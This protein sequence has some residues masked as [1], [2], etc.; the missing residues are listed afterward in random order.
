MRTITDGCFADC[1]PHETVC[2]EAQLDAA[3]VLVVTLQQP[4]ICQDKGES[5]LLLLSQPNVSILS[6]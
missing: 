3:A 4:S 6:A 2:K 5:K 1:Q